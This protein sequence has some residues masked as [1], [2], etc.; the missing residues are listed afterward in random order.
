M[1]VQREL[2]CLKQLLQKLLYALKKRILV[3]EGRFVYL[4]LRLVEWIILM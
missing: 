1:V 3:A 2:V 4:H